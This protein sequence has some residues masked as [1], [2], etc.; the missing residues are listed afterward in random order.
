MKYFATI[1]FLA[2]LC[3]LAS[4]RGAKLSVADEQFERG[5]YYDASV[6][7]KKVYNKLRKK[8]ERPLRGEVAFKM[9]N[10]Y[11]LLNMSSRSSAAY[12]NALRYE[13]PDSMA[14]F[15]LA[16]ALQRDGKYAAAIESYKRYLEFCPSDTLAINGVQGCEDALA[17]RGHASRYEV[18]NARLFN[19]RRSDFSPM[20]L[21]ADYD[22]LYFTSTTEKAIGDKKSEITGMKNADVFFSK[23]NDIKYLL[24]KQIDFINR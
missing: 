7:Y 2:A 20:Y 3:A 10:C 11:R 19:S 16:Q 14:H 8:E 6:T 17:W 18:K 15:Y 22:Q 5:E 23:K 1:L 12:Q 21:G 13:Y 4:C 24:S 9:G